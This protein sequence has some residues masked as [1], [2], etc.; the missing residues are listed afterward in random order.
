MIGSCMFWERTSGVCEKF[1]DFRSNFSSLKLHI[2]PKKR[3]FSSIVFAFLYS[4]VNSSCVLE[5]PF[6][7]ITEHTGSTK[8]GC[9]ELGFFR[10]CLYLF[11][12]SI[13]T[14]S[15]SNLP[16]VD[17]ANALIRASVC[18]SVFLGVHPKSYRIFFR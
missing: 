11:S 5:L 17:I 7:A 1:N 15:S 3:S 2:A 9:N 12:D 14:S 8:S 10:N 18:L 6:H 16:N 13:V 4:R